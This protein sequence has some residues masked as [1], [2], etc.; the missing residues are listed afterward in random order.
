MDTDKAFLTLL[1]TLDS[2]CDFLSSPNS[3]SP[4]TVQLLPLRTEWHCFAT[5]RLLTSNPSGFILVFIFLLQALALFFFQFL[6]LLTCASLPL[7]LPKWSLSSVLLSSQLHAARTALPQVLFLALVSH[8]SPLLPW[9]SPFLS[10]LH[11]IQGWPCL[12]NTNAWNEPV[13]NKTVFHSTPQISSS[14]GHLPCAFY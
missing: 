11:H 13:W 2:F 7:Y 10:P 6:S 1:K 12:W 3:L 5:T 9:D 14:E 8:L 4:P